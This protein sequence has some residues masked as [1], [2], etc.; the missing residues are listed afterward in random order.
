[1]FLEPLRTA[2]SHLAVSDMAFALR[3]PGYEVDIVSTW[4]VSAEKASA[5]R[6]IKSLRDDLH[7]FARGV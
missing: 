3:L 6:G 5:V 4:S 2:I 7:R 1:V